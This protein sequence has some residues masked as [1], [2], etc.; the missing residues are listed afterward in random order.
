[1][2]D[3][4]RFTDL[5]NRSAALKQRVATELSAVVVDAVAS[6]ER[7]L[8]AGGTLFFCGNGGSASDSQHLATELV[9]RLRAKVE[10]G[11]WPAMAL[12]ADTSAVTACGN[13]YGFE[14]IFERPLRGLGRPGD[15]L[16]GITTSG[17]SANV[18]RALQAAR[19]MGMTTVGLLGGQGEPASQNCDHP[20]I[21]PSDQTGLI[22]ECHIAIGHALLE[23]LEDRLVNSRFTLPRR[24]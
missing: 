19:E 3:Q 12:S 4:V 17:R 22:Q 9:I 8:R 15:V 6:C 20:I 14:H 1:M 16:F 5:L 13:D 24:G 18:I 7:S 23:L 2:D 21:V 11:S 10:R